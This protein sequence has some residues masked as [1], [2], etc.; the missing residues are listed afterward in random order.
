MDGERLGVRLQ[1]PVQ[2]AHTRELLAQLGFDA[3]AID[4]LVAREGR[5]V[6]TRL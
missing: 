4:D 2:G 5:G 3:A 6:A 1:P